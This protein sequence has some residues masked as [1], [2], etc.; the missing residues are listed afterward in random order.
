M[1]D[2]ITR[3]LYGGRVT[4]D[5]NPK[6]HRYHVSDIKAAPDGVTT[7]ANA[8]APFLGDD[9]AGRIN[10]REARDNCLKVFEETGYDQSTL[11]AICEHAETHHQRVRDGAGDSGSAVHDLVEKH[12]KGKEY[13][14][15]D[16][17]NVV[18]G[19]KVFL[20]WMEQT[21]VEIL[22]IERLVY[23][24]KYFYCG[25]TDFVGRQNGKLLIGD[26]KAGNSAGYEKEWY[27]LAGYAVAIEEETGDKIDHGLIV[28][29][30]K[31]TNRFKEYQVYLGEDPD[32]WSMKAAWKAAVVHYKNL[33][34][35][36]KLAEAKRNGT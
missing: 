1:T 34:R 12:L 24:E 4:V 20:S 5:L 26:F 32:S 18:A 23:S 8:A 6:S 33:K 13:S 35:V 3:K 9:W 36:R 7:I 31:K 11:L 16:D 22:E 30:D 25:K 10:V 21:D 29:L 27:Q 28:H 17:A 15:P 19:F 14:L 2:I